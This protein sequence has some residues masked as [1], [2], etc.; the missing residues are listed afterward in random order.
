MRVTIRHKLITNLTGV[1]YHV[2]SRCNMYGKGQMRGTISR[3]RLHGEYAYAILAEDPTQLIGSST[4]LLGC[5]V[6][7]PGTY[8]MY[9][10]REHRRLGIG[11][12]IY[13]RAERICEAKN[14][15]LQGI[16]WDER[17]KLFYRSLE[18][19]ELVGA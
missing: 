9:V 10:R 7:N 2:Y 15:R 17:S 16:S 8:M 6:V 14:W 12:R 1:E 5:A 11:T 4:R 19:K 3:A 18:S 13:R